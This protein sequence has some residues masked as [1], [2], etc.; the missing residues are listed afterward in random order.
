MSEMQGAGRGQEP[1]ALFEEI[2]DVLAGVGTQGMGVID[3]AA[4]RLHS[5]DFAQ[6]NDLLDMMADVEAALG[7]MIVVG[8]RPGREVQERQEQP[9]VAHAAALRSNSRA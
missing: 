3:G 2:G 9:L 5:V 4:G 7:E 1:L 8:L 6:G